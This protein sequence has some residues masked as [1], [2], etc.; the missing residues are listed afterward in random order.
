MA[1]EFNQVRPPAVAGMFYPDDPRE[2]KQQ[3]DFFLQNLEERPIVGEIYGI[4]SPHA[5]YIYSGQVAAAAYR[6]LLRHDYRYVAVVAP[7]HREYFNGI[8]VLPAI[9]Y[10]TPLGE[11]KIATDLCER[12]IEQSEI[13][14]PSWAGHREEHALEVQ[15]PFLQRVLGEFELIPLVMGDQNYDYAVELGE[16][17]AKVLRHE[18]SLVVAS[19]D[20]S[21]YYPASEAERMDRRVLDRINA[22]DYE[23]FWDDVETRRVEACGAGPIVAAMVA[24]KKMGA[25]KAEVLMY[26]HSGDVTGDLSAV[27][28]YMSAAF[29]HA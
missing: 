27:V 19:S 12:L 22:Y 11:V 2:L 8:S 21:H 23:G 9:S 3:I 10:E 26:R 1:V 16:V 24:A 5:G 4:V 14:L 20:L 29:Y 7:S 18:K 13:I 28:G 6:Q 25:N 17:L 15:L